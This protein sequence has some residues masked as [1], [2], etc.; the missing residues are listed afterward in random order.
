LRAEGKNK[1]RNAAG[2]LSVAGAFWLAS[3][4]CSS[5]AAYTAG[6]LIEPYGAVAAA[7][8]AG[9]DPLA[10]T[11]AY[12]SDVAKDNVKVVDV[13]LRVF[14]EA[15]IPYFPLIIPV[16]SRPTRMAVSPDQQKV[17]VVNSASRDISVIDTALNIEAGA[18]V[19]NGREFVRF[20]PATGAPR[21]IQ[22]GLMM[23]DL[24]AAYSRST[25]RTRL[26]V[27]ADTG[28]NKGRLIVVDTSAY[29]PGGLENPGVHRSLWEA[30]L[31]GVPGRLDVGPDGDTVYLSNRSGK[32]VAVADTISKSITEIDLGYPTEVVKAVPDEA[33][34]GRILLASSKSARGLWVIDLDTMTP[35]TFGLS[36]SRP[37][38]TMIP[39]VFGIPQALALSPGTSLGGTLST[40]EARDCPGMVALLSMLNGSVS[41]LDVSGCARQTYAS[42]LQVLGKDA[43]LQGLFV[44]TASTSPSITVPELAVGGVT[45]SQS[46]QFFATYPRIE[47]WDR[48]DRNYG[49]AISP[50]LRQFVNQASGFVTYEGVVISGASGTAT[51]SATFTEAGRDFV[52]AGV[53]AGSDWLV[54][55]GADGTPR[56]TCDDGTPVAVA[57]FLITAVEKTLMTVQGPMPAA[58]CVAGAVSWQVRPKG[59]WTVFLEG[60]GI[61]GRAT[62]GTQFFFPPP[63]ET[64]KPHLA[65]TVQSGTQPSVRDM[66]FSFSMGFNAFAMF[67]PEAS[68]MPTDIHVAADSINFGR[69][70][71]FV[72]YSGS[73]SLFQFAPQTLDT[74]VEVIYK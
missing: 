22:I 6:N 43:G 29:L 27:A 71:A 16:G 60:L 66:V 47:G 10:H 69:Q 8:F 18:E 23:T 17:Y 13:S 4:A 73:S 33:G 35:R 62:P 24:S 63:S 51:D 53:E 57:E 26:Y 1:G 2:A 65:L 40:D 32:A 30:D 21:R 56:T 42:G 74:Q 28:D 58:E 55:T 68:F 72:V 34:A 59:M 38:G 25:G 49:V 48:S 37:L 45:L 19:W 5:P 14:Q 15:P 31:P 39:S 12:V 20:D 70:W 64:D 54:L 67:P 9:T 52:L 7:P 46:E 44:E 61:L 41:A 3:A 11:Y 50:L 36:P